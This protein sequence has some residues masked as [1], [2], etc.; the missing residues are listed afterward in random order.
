MANS[1]KTIETLVKLSEN[2]V[3]EKQKEISAIQERLDAMESRK[4]HLL[5]GMETE[6]QIAADA[7]TPLMYEMAGKFQAKAEDELDLL[8]Q[9][10]VLTEKELAEKRDELIELYQEQKTNDIILERKKEAIKKE[11]E[12]KDI[13]ELDEIASKMH[14]HKKI[15]D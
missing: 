11:R 14:R 1:I 10:I 4:K 5:D 15:N 6:V 8:G 9:A 2:A 12:K 3:E 7:S 13:A